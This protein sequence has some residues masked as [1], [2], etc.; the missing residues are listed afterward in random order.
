MLTPQSRR[1]IARFAE[2]G[3]LSFEQM[4]V[5]EARDSVEAGASLMP[6]PPE[7]ALVREL[8]VDGSQGR[9]PARLYHPGPGRDLPLVVFFHGGGWVTGSVATAD[10]GC[11]AL[12]LACGVAVLSVAYRLAPETPAPGPG[13]DCLA[14]YRWALSHAPELGVDRARV[15]V[16]GDSAGGTLAAGLCLLARDRGLVPPV[17]QVLLYPPLVPPWCASFPS[18]QD[19]AE[20]FGLTAAG[21]TWFWEHYLAGRR[22]PDA[23]AAPL[24]AQDL[25][26]LPPA[27]VVTA[28]H[29]PLCDEGEAFAGALSR[30]GTPSTLLSYDGAIHGFLSMARVLPEGVRVLGDVHAFLVSHNICQQNS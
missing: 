10:P 20:G 2:A 19:N 29:D 27:L 14:A 26:G 23:Y 21:M 16:M 17:A 22:E 1:L 6:T 3:V 24:L 7:V 4:G 9:L 15:L 30:A 12:A 11:R 18:W 28:E 25:S 13:L 8:L 5:Q